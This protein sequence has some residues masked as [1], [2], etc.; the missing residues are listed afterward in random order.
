MG[1]DL[2]EDRQKGNI[3]AGW[4]H[5][6]IKIKYKEKCP[7]RD[8]NSY[9]LTSATPSRWCVYQFRHLGFFKKFIG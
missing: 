3:E 6:K 2:P 8:S 4:P 1:R 9:T 7:E 5:K